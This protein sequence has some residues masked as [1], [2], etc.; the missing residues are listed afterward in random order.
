MPPAISDANSYDHGLPL[1]V[2]TEA[3]VPAI[4][5]LINAAFVVERPIFEN[6]RIDDAGVRDYMTRG[7]FLLHEDAAGKLIACVYLEPGK[8]GRCYLGLLD[9]SRATGN[10]SRSTHPRRIGKMRTRGRLPYDV[11]AHAQR[12]HPTASSLLRAPGLQVPRNCSAPAS[13]SPE[14]F[15]RVRSDGKATPVALRLAVAAPIRSAPSVNTHNVTHGAVPPVCAG[16]PCDSDFI[17]P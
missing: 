6:D 14:N 7:R 11:A 12:S 15:M 9:R 8:D 13:F 17:D 4:T 2:A 16:L 10:G 1:R 5:P 3:D